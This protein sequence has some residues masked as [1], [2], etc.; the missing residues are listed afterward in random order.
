[1]EFVRNAWVVAAATQEVGRQPLRRKLLGEPVVFFRQEDGR[2]VALF[3]RCAHRFAPLSRGRLE[4]DVIRCAYHGLA[5]DATGAC[6]HNPHGGAIPSQARTRSFPLLERYGFVWIWMGDAAAADPG[7]LADLSPFDD[8]TDCVRQGSYLRIDAHYQLIVDNLLD[9]SHVEYLHPAF[10][11]KD[12]IVNTRHEVTEGPDWIQSNRYK[13][14]CHVSPLLSRCWGKEGAFG[15]ARSCIRWQAPGTFFLEIGA[16]HAG[17]PEADGVTLPILHLLT[18]ETS[19]ST[20]Y[21]WAVRRDVQLDDR[22]LDAWL[23]RTLGDAF[24]Q[25]D[26]PMIEAQQEQIGM[27]IDINALGP[28]FL[29]PDVAPVKARRIVA[30]LLKEQGVAPSAVPFAASNFNG[31]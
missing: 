27:D 4:G 8:E 22:D 21:F 18:P 20:H 13:P 3:D 31:A 9:L 7:L 12:A 23:E 29:P 1:M 5:Y 24:L 6:V 28:V 19:R 25:E 30:R 14:G 26:E 16:T 17:A 15:D 2:P 10:A 11:S